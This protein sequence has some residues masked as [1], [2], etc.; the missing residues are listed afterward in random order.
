MLDDLDGSRRRKRQGL[1][2]AVA[3]VLCAPSM[4]VTFQLVTTRAAVL[5]WIGLSVFVGGALAKVFPAR[6]VLPKL[7]DAELAEMSG[8]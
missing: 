7:S 8:S 5:M 3:L 1:F 2:I 4:Y 6:V